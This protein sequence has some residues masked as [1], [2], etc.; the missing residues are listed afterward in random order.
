MI[1]DPMK[2]EKRKKIRLASLFSFSHFIDSFKT[3]VA[4]R[5][6]SART[7]LFCLLIGLF[8]VQNMIVGELDILYPFLAQVGSANIFDY[9]FGLKSFFG[10]V[11]L[12]LII[13]ISKYSG[14]Y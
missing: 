5:Q 12:L 4:P 11:S 6:G 3:V 13:P 1:K 8:I 14:K 10:A 2:V 7:S 9:F